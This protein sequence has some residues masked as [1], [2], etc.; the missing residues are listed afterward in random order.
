MDVREK[1]EHLKPS[2]ELKLRINLQIIED[3]KLQLLAQQKDKKKK[4]VLE[5]FDALFFPEGIEI[6]TALQIPSS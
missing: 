5:P 3:I 6:Q 4:K 1:I 2:E